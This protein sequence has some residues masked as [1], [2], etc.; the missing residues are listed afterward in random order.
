MKKV[1]VEVK[2]R[3]VINMDE[4]ET[5][6]EVINEMDYDFSSNSDGADIEDTQILD[7]EV[8]DAK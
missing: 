4:G 6:E 5:V 1:F 2:A 3:L 8:T 7:Y